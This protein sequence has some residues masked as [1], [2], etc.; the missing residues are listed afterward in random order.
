MEIVDAQIHRPPSPEWAS[1]S[2]PA[3]AIDMDIELAIAAM[4]AVGVDAAVIHTVDAD[5]C[6]A[7]AAKYP[8]RFASVLQLPGIGASYGRFEEIPANAEELVGALRTPAVL[9]FR[10]VIAWPPTGE[11]LYLLRNGHLDPW[12]AAAEKHAVPVCFFASGHLSE[13]GPVAERYPA[14]SLILDH[15][16]MLPVPPVAPSAAILDALPELLSLAR[17]PNVAVKFTGVAALSMESYPFDDLWPRMHE[18]IA[19]F[20]PERLLWGSDYTRIK[21]RRTYAE[22]LD[23][24]LHT[25]EISQSDKELMLAGAARRWLG[26]QKAPSAESA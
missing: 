17:F 18:V 21:G 10:V 13:V 11:R 20:G 7:A 25:S 9:G 22:L 19:A 12:F 1:G 2:D 6:E 23:F 24:L 15:I 26:W 8:H 14:L 4:D 16:G 3:V 5:F